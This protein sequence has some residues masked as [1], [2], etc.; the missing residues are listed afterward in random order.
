MT[1]DAT[2][3][4]DPIPIGAGTATRLPTPPDPAD[5]ADVLW[6]QLEAYFGWYS[7]WAGRNRIAY[8]CLKVG[9]L[10]VGAAVTVLAAT[11]APAALTA[12]FAAALV[13]AEGAQ[14]LFQFHS[15]WISYRATAEELRRHAYAYAAHLPPYASPSTRRA[16][17]SALLSEATTRENEAWVT[18]M[19]ESVASRPTGT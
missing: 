16:T 2:G 11:R 3:S 7:R 14:Q 13:V 19:R 8:Q 18:T 10:V 9:A 5:Q 6:G 12:S 1:S 15:N 4:R 17:L